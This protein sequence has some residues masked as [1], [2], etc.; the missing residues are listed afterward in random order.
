MSKEAQVKETRLH[1]LLKEQKEL[2]KKL[3]KDLGNYYYFIE[4]ASKL[5]KVEEELFQNKVFGEEDILNAL[6]Y[7]HNRKYKGFYYL[8]GFLKED[9]EERDENYYNGYGIHLMFVP[10]FYEKKEYV[11][12]YN[13]LGGAKLVSIE[14]RKDFEHEN[15]II[16]GKRMNIPYKNIGE[17][18]KLMQAHNPGYSQIE[19]DFFKYQKRFWDLSKTKTSDEI[20]LANDLI[21]SEENKPIVKT[22]K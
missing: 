18:N 16:I 5:E 11:L 15:Y 10:P 6:D 4:I 1:D 17:Y 9:E 12:Y 3:K 2:R 14:D 19:E 21:E 22:K 7:N 13:L 20:I 8:F